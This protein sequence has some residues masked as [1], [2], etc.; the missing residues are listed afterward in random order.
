MTTRKRTL[1]AVAAVPAPPEAPSPTDPPSG[2]SK[3]AKAWWREEVEQYELEAHHLRLLSE[4][5]W[6]WDRCQSARALVDAEG[7][8]VRDRFGQSKPHPATAIERDARAA[9]TRI[10]REL[11]L[12]GAT[13]PESRPPR[14]SRNRS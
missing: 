13:S 8:V 2:L 14:A 4:A 5:A 12:D 10:M 9:Y 11:D 3:A 7:M 6:A 1:K